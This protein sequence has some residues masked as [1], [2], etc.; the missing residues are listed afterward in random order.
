[1]KQVTLVAF[2]GQKRQ[3]FR[4]LINAIFSEIEQSPLGSNF[5]PYQMNQ[6]HGTLVGMEKMA[7]SEEFYNFNIW[8]K[9]GRKEEMNF[10][11]IYSNVAL[12]FPVNIQFGGFN[13]DYKG[14]SS[15]GGIPFNRTF[16]IS[17]TSKK[18]IL[19]GWSMAEGKKV[20]DKKLLE[21][22]ETLQDQHNIRP[23][24]DNDNDLYMVIGEFQNL[25]LLPEKALATL[26]ES[27]KKLERSI[28]NKLAEN[29]EELIL[30][31]ED[32]FYVQYESRT[33]DYNTS[34]AWSIEK[35]QN[36]PDF[37]KGLY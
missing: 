10:K 25:E 8:E 27:G 4:N 23:K 28:R 15:L 29:K 3:N 13:E 26:K 16:E 18:V 32:L 31:T 37:L 36:N 11:H 20:A 35:V 7:G 22:R 24:M 33:L 2:Y 30:S 9:E 5:E 21:A 12:F 1:M 17:W 34:K 14:F 19:I 6:I